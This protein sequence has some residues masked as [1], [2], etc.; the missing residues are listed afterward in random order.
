[1]KNEIQSRSTC[2]GKKSWG[3]FHQR[4]YKFTS[5]FYAQR[6]QKCK[7]L[8]NLTVFLMLLGSSSVKAARRKTLVK[9]TP[10][11]PRIWELTRVKLI[12]SWPPEL[13]L[14]RLSVV[15][16]LPLPISSDSVESMWVNS[17]QLFSSDGTVSPICIIKS[18]SRNISVLSML[19][20][21]G[22][23]K[24]NS[25]HASQQRSRKN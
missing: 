21:S 1:M 2:N 3:Q 18:K 9:L 14:T 7:K 10:G 22:V 20:F 17:E 25:I 11:G 24:R 16:M 8:L 19:Q 5:S 13:R 12:G 6:S 23:L 4:V 15:V